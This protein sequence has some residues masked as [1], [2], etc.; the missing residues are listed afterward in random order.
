[1]IIKVVSDRAYRVHSSYQLRRLF[2]WLSGP[3]HIKCHSN[4]SPQPFEWGKNNNKKN[5]SHY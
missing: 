4:H 2:R 5:K 1:M 3:E